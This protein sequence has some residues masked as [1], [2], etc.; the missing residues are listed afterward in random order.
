MVNGCELWIVRHGE[1]E[2]S[3]NGR[4][5]STTDL[6]LTEDGERVAGRLRERLAGMSF[7][8][9]LSSPRRRAL[10]TAELAG[11]ES[12]EVDVDLAEWEYGDYEG[13]TTPQIRED[14][15]GWTVWADGCPGGES[16]EGVGERLDRVVQRVRTNGGHVLAFGHGHSSRVLTA[17]WLGLP[18][19]D[20]RHFRL[21]T[22]TVSTLGSARDAPVVVRWNS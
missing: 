10:H 17:R 6:D 8:L 12:P 7:D 5:T 20:G 11:F 4:H 13:I 1:T 22:A 21:D 3:R 19:A 2:W 18:T 16:P 9:V 14:A 15:P